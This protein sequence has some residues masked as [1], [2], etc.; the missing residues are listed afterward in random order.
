[1]SS[2][3]DRIKEF[4]R[5]LGIPLLGIAGPERLNGPPSLDPTYTMKGARSIISLALPMDVPAIYDFLGK[6][7]PV[8][9]N[10]DQTR[11][12]QDIHRL[13]KKIAA[14]I[15]TSLGFRARAVPTNNNYRRSPDA[16]AT[17]PD[18]S[19][20]FGAIVSGLAAAGWSGN[21]M[22]EEFGAAI[23]LCTVVTDA[24][25][26]SDPPRYSPRHFVDNYCY[27]CRL[28]EKTCVAGMFE[29]KEEEYVLLNGELHPRGKRRDIN[30]CNA[31]CFGLHSL[32]RDKKWTTWGWRWIRE[33]VDEEPDPAKT[34]IKLKLL[35]EGGKTGDSTPRYDLIRRIGSKIQD[36]ELINKYVE[37]HP[38][39]LSESERFR[40]SFLPFAEKI[41]VK[42]F[43]DERILTCGQCAL[44]CGPTIEESMNRYHLLTESGLVAPGPNNEM[45]N[46]STYEEAVEMRRKY[47]PRVPKSLK[48]K[49]GIAS[50]WMFHKYY[51]GFEPKSILGGALYR[52]Q[53]KKAVAEKARGHLDNSVTSGD[54]S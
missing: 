51:F 42:G 8:P 4:S 6:K 52:R 39:K 35:I 50:G 22:T 29:A 16:F 38:E 32:S 11:K 26:H 25:L 15:E 7:S 1:M 53:L 54:D 24:E 37:S 20:R 12:N 9:H 48:I 21:V 23:Y 47:L 27:K 18:F 40:K 49:D 31:S 30:L 46:V 19:H 33:W 43:I 45:V 13:A 14:F 2:R 3:E 36:E 34:N 41:G 10:L 28:C 17:H 5:S 44:V